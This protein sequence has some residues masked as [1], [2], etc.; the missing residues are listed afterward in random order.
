MIKNHFIFKSKLHG[1]NQV[2]TMFQLL[3]FLWYMG[4]DGNGNSNHRMRLFF[5]CGVGTIQKAKRRVLTSLLALKTT[6][7]HWPDAEERLEIAKRF[8][9]KFDFPHCV[10]IIDGTLFPL[11]TKPQLD[12]AAG[13]N[14]RKL[15]Y[16]I[17]AIILCDDERRIQMYMVGNPGTCHN[18]RAFWQ[19]E[20]AK[21]P[22]EFLPE[23]QY[24]LGDSAFT[25]RGSLVPAYKKPAGVPM[26]PEHEKFNNQLSKP[27]VISEH[28]N[29]MLK[30][31]FR[32]LNNLPMILK[33]RRTMIIILQHIE[34]LIILHNLL[35]DL[36][37][38]IPNSWLYDADDVSA[39]DESKTAD[40]DNFFP[41][42]TQDMDNTERR[43]Q[44]MIYHDHIIY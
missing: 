36:K 10:F 21:N 7:I 44:L 26:P 37:D 32:I 30:C 39:V 42:I 25:P 34:V 5:H 33:D 15:G 17:N 6:A 1:P 38:E 22:L 9:D 16:T 13:Y 43:E 4:I 29:G 8:Q 14:G 23:R 35:I 19:M 3:I 18:E 41:T 27:C 40:L 11:S 20:I 28:V 24:G 2:N 31:R 12:D